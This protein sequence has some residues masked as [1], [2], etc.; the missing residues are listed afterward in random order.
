VRFLRAAVESVLE[1]TYGD[2]ECLVFD[3]GSTDGSWEIARELESRDPRV[4]VASHEGRRNRGIVPTVNAAYA[5]A[6]G[7]YIAI[8]AADDVL[9]PYS[10]ERRV[11]VFGSDPGAALVYGRI[12]MLD[13]EGRPTGRYGGVSPE[14]ICRFDGTD[15]ALQALLL[16]DYVPS[17][18]VLLRR[19][20][21]AETG[22][23]ADVYYNDWELWLRLL[24]RGAR[25]AFV[26]G[27]AL[28]GCRPG[29]HADD[30]DLPRRLEIFRALAASAPSIGGRFAEPR[31]R[32]LVCLQLA[33]QAAQLGYDDE[34]KE[35]IRSAFGVDSSLRGDT[36]YL[37][38]WLG[39][40]QRRRLPNSEPAADIVWVESLRDPRVA[41]A[42]AMAAGAQAGHFG[43]WA[44]EAAQAELSVA[45]LA[46]VRWA[47]IS[48]QLELTGPRPR[49]L[50]F[51]ALLVRAMHRPRLLSERGFVKALL[52]SAGLWS[53]AA[54]IRRLV[55]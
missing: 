9:L 7:S 43:C 25:F 36:G 28:V 3:D 54:G 16:H 11:A 34:A 48:E 20:L 22:G 52:C 4:R 33:L 10:V 31:V 1:Q 5:R 24:A 32:A 37:F 51:G 19:N 27:A 35:G 12:E 23:F 47:L 42:S 29:A 13:A 14:A 15:D 21:F 6:R 38:W 46:S 53:V 39:P 26:D 18:T 30:A 49:P 17:P 41:A 44:L 45:T 8:L 2:L 40:L 55:S 50:L